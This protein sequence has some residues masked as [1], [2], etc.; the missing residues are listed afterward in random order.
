[1]LIRESHMK[2]FPLKCEAL[3]MPSLHPLPWARWRQSAVNRLSY[4]CAVTPESNSVRTEQAAT[5]P[6]MALT[7]SEKTRRSTAKR[8]AKIA[9]MPKIPCRCNCG[10]LIPPITKQFEPARYA[11]GHN[12]AGARTRFQKNH[13]TWNK[14]AKG[15]T[16][17]RLGDTLSPKEIELRTA[18]RLQ[19][20]GGRYTSA[21]AIKRGLI[22]RPASWRSNVTAANRRRDLSGPSNPAWMGGLTREYGPGLTRRLRAAIRD[23]DGHRCQRCGMTEARHGRT[24]V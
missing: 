13:K 18:T 21:A 15:L 3:T 17:T 12:G 2:G 9:A 22:K 1:M 4:P 8:L 20:N 14:G 19:R 7:P 10:T 23:R 24:L 5:I 16:P 6:D 11:H